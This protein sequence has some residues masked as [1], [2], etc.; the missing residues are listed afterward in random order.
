MSSKR[1]PW[2]F[3]FVACF[4]VFSPADAQ[5]GKKKD[6]ETISPE[7]IITPEPRTKY[8][9]KSF[10]EVIPSYAITDSGLFTTYKVGQ[11]YYYAI[12]DS[13]LDRDFLWISRIANIPAGL[14]GSYFNAGRKVNEQV[15][16]WE[17]REKSILLRTKSYNAYAADSLPITLSVRANNFQPAIC[18]FPIE[19]RSEDS[20]A[21]VIEVTKLFL[22]DIRAF[23]GLT[24][25]L[26]KEY[27]VSKLDDD[28]CFI[29]SMKSFPLN[30]EVRHELTY[31]AAEPPSNTATGV[32][33][34]EMNQSLILLPK[35]PMRRRYYDERVGW[36]TVKQIDYGS[37]AL[38]A[39]EKAFIRR[40]RLE[41]SDREAYAR[42]ELVEPV[43]PIIYYL[44]PATP[45]KFR[46][47]IKAGVEQWQ[48]ALES[49]GFKN[50]IIARDAPSPKEDPDFSP[51]DVRYSVIRYVASTTRNAMGPSVTDPRSGEIIE[52]D[53]F[54]YH[55]HLRSYRNRYLLE[56][57]AANTSARTLNTPLADIGEMLKQ[58]ITHEVGHALGLP[59]NMRASFCYLTDSL[60]S[61]T[62][63]QK[64]GIAASVMDYAR[65]NYVAQPG[66]SNIRFIRKIGPYDYYA[67]NWGYRWIPAATTS[68]QEVPI[69]SGW[70]E[71]K[72]DNPV[73]RFGSGQ[74][75]FD[76]ASQTECIG[77]DPLK[78]SSYGLQNLRI[79][80]A[81]LPDWTSRQT[82]DYDDLA[83][84][85][86]ELISVWG[87]YVDHVITNV[88]GVYEDRI[89][90]DQPGY[91]YTPVN[92]DIQKRSM[93]WLLK[94]AFNSPTWL[95][96]VKIIRNI[97]PAD[98]VERIRQFQVVHLNSLLSFERLSRLM[99]NEVN[100]VGYSALDMIRQLQDGIWKELGRRSA[101]DIYRR[102]LQKAYLERMEYLLFS[103]QSSGKLDP[104][105]T[106]V[107]VKESDIRSIVRGELDR[108]LKLLRSARPAYGNT[109]AGYHLSDA[110][111]RIQEM[112]NPQYTRPAK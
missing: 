48:K 78:A 13:L 102:N 24:A 41:P 85:Y 87:R 65:F 45:E 56:T 58:V 51:E 82:N 8:R 20:T 21:S 94:N 28:R 16:T 79:V 84:L 110:E 93:E 10:H 30:I 4:L 101:I 18:A 43:K 3:A 60:R 74:G 53:I 46:P 70:I 9:I 44:D 68:E 66:D 55:N 47:F 98:H 14:G 49:A 108:L 2:S 100:G 99:E 23:S 86:R 62:F 111:S 81:N 22:S 75:G 77:D 88:G 5:R 52:S 15:V 31:E 38:K 57:G 95:F 19:T 72:K 90:P 97:N 83:E 63:T 103:E 91:F 50:A 76:P 106:K 54:W 89:K 11:K 107:N 7:K 34:L 42:G 17:K 92:A 27:K 36:F 112:L 64:N 35:K 40:W 80:A 32:I 104:G 67:I 39:D 12:P 109:L 59:H 33:S 71:E 69:L 29:N 105:Q 96:Q 37:N 26:R 73:Y 61:G 25:G 6:K 1:V